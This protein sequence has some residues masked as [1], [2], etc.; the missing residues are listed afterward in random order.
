[1]GNVTP[2]ELFT[3]LFSSINFGFNSKQLLPN[4]YFAADFVL[5]EKQGDVAKR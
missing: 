4:T 5:K 3:S 2:E 1:M